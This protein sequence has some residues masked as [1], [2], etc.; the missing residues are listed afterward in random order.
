MG[1]PNLLCIGAQKAGTTWFHGMLAQHP[2]VYRGPLKE[3]HY[4]N[5]LLSRAHRRRAKRIVRNRLKKRIAEHMEISGNSEEELAWL[6][7]LADR[8]RIFKDN[9]YEEVFSGPGSE[10][11]FKFETTPAYSTL[12]LESI[13]DIRTLLGDISLVY[14][15]RDP[16]DRILSQIRMKATK[17]FGDDEIKEKKW[18]VLLNN[19]RERGDYQAYIPRWL[20][21]FPESSVHFIPF[22]T[23]SA[24]PDSVMRDAEAF[25]GLAP[26][27][28]EDLRRKLHES[29]RFDVPPSVVELLA[30]H[31]APQYA[32]LEQHF[33]KDFMKLI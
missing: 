6:E 7:S 20:S 1:F 21:V 32:F 11:K 27:R 26:H 12:P 33:G 28:Y 4:F 3:C 29:T 13:K 30:E 17:R 24:E 5:A 25:L 16:L 23:I 8:K 9:W 18:L 19:M 2:D 14:I 31:V 15:I 10:G 22:K